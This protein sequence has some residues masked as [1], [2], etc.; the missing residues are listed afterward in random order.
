[1]EILKRIKPKTVYKPLTRT[2]T[3]KNDNNRLKIEK[4]GKK[5]KIIECERMLLCL[6][7]IDNSLYKV[8]K[9][10]II[11]DEF[12]DEQNKEIAKIVFINLAGEETSGVFANFDDNIKAV[13]DIIKKRLEDRQKEILQQLSSGNLSTEDSEK[14][15]LELKEV[16][17]KMKS[18]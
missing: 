10:K 6:L 9:D 2:L 3:A 11:V 15:K 7:S 1:L 16:L 8:V 4:N 12:K 18:I 5:N 17:L 14:L 13:M